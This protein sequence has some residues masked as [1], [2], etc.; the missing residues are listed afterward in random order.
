MITKKLMV[1]AIDEKTTATE[2]VPPSLKSPPKEEG[3]DLAKQQILLL[4]KAN[5]RA[6]IDLIVGLSQI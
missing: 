5:I 3:L 2:K 6:S 4:A 1:D